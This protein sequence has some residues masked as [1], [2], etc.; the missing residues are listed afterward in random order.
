M[1]AF[2]VEPAEGVREWPPHPDRLFAALVRAHCEAAPGDAERAALRWMAALPPPAIVVAPDGG[3]VPVRSHPERGHY[4]RRLP[5]G[6]LAWF[7]WP[8]GA[9]AEA[10]ARLAAAVPRLRLRAPLP[11]AVDRALAAGEAD[12]HRALVPR[13]D[14]A[15]SLRVCD[16]GCLERWL[17]AH[18]AGRR[19][20]AGP[21]AAYGPPGASAR[22]PGET[23]VFRRSEGDRLP[24]IAAPRVLRAVRE[25]LLSLAAD[26]LPEVLS[27]HTPDGAPTTR[28]HVAVVPLAD[29]GHGTASGDLLGFA[30]VLPSGIDRDDRGRILQALRS[31]TT[32]T[33]GSTGAWRVARAD[34]GEVPVGPARRWASVTPVVFDRHPKPKP[35]KGAADVIARSCADV[36]LP[37]PVA[38]EV[39]AVSPVLAVPPAGHFPAWEAA[40]AYRAHV[41][42]ELAAPVR[43]PVMLGRGRF[44]GMGL[45]RP[46]P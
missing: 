30:V 26:P 16:A 21:W 19:G 4:E 17:D 12:G 34:A 33:M 25:A 28:P 9:H 2:E 24:L 42:I 20:A 39:G 36:G 7:V 27:G 45:L 11:D 1:I 23:F 13:A 3:F 18:A 37:A 10:L 22:A 40:P 41:V 43:G 35:G 14:G 46:L 31:L 5:E 44:L 6:A 38:V 32:L 29:V 15:S 8:E